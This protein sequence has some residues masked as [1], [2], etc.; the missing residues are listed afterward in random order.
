MN[1]I[2]LI[3]LALLLIASVAGAQTTFVN[4][5]GVEAK[6]HHLKAVVLLGDT[7]RKVPKAGEMHLRFFQGWD[8][9]D[10]KTKAPADVS[11]FAPGPTLRARI[12]DKV[13]IMFLNAIDDSAFPYTFVTANG[14]SNPAYGCDA[15]ANLGYYP[16]KDRFPNCFHGSSTANLHFHGTHTTPDA[17]GDNVLVQVMPDKTVTQGQW[18]DTFNKIFAA[19]KI[20]STWPEMQLS[21]YA[22]RQEPLVKEQ[23]P[24]GPD[25]WK[26]NEH[27]VALGEFPQYM[28]GAFPNVFDIPDYDKCKLATPPCKAGQAP[29]THWY[30]AHKHGSTTMHISNGL[31]GALIIEGPYDDFFKTLYQYK[32][33]NRFEKVLIFQ[34]INPDQNLE[35][36]SRNGPGQV[37]VSGSDNPI[38]NMDLGEVQLWRIINA[39]QGSIGGGAGPGIVGPDV[40]TTANNEL[41]FLQTAK[42]GVQFSPKNLRAQPFLNGTIPNSAGQNPG[43]LLSAGNRADVLVQAKTAGEY[44]LQSGGRDVLRVVVSKTKNSMALPRDCTTDIKKD[45]TCWPD[46]PPFLADLAPPRDYP[47]TVTFGWDAEPGRYQAGG[48]R[49]ASSAGLGLPPKF[50]IDNHQFADYGERVDQCMPLGSTQDWILENQTTITHP[51]HIHINPFQIIKI[52]V[53]QADGSYKTYAPKDNFVW[54]DVVPIPAGV[55]LANGTFIPGRVAIRQQ[56]VDFTGT[57]VLHCHILAHEDRGMMQLVR[58]V[59]ADKFPEKCQSAIPEH[60]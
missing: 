19:P 50:T 45:S 9:A 27:M 22:G 32:D 2:L 43:L 25:L 15:T 54:H 29:G 48:G 16:A 11:I 57:Y 5:A 14:K 26:N 53:P 38:I 41:T 46:M 59:P 33:R 58:V 21:G 18:Q 60:H 34:L 13:E 17:L 40:F 55:V 3:L 7:G 35:R 6:D 47:H 24:D 37:L 42:D 8:Q 52:E 28:V 39:T 4:P 56:F 49:L 23:K 1:K 20:P 12:G 36:Q 30:H 31:A 44:Q 10:P 51:F